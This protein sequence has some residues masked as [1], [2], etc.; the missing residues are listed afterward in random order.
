MCIKFNK[1]LVFE[2]LPGFCKRSFGDDALGDFQMIER[3]KIVIQLVLVGA[4]I[5]VHQKKDK[6]M[7][8]Q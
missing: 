8:G 1:G 2:F 6:L 4:F 5:H 3:F 7:K